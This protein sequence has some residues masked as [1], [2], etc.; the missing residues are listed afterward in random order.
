MQLQEILYGIAITNLVGN[1][2][3]EVGAL[4]FDSRQVKKGDVFLQ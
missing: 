4:V 1:T 2:N 3:K